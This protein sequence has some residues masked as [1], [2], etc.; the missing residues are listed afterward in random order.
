M[1]SG[2][3]EAKLMQRIREQLLI[4]H[5]IDHH[6]RSTIVVSPSEIA[7]AAASTPRLNG[8]PRRAPHGMHDRE[9][10]VVHGRVHH[11][12]PNVV[13]DPA[14]VRASHLLIRVTDQRSEERALALATQLYD[15]LLKGAD[16]EA[17]A[18]NYSEGP[19]AADGGLLGWVRPGE[20]LPELDHALFRLV[21][22][23]LSSPIRTRLGF[24]LVK[25]VERR[26]RSADEAVET[27]QHLEER[28][29]QEKFRDA[30]HQWLE[31]LRQRAYIEF[32]NE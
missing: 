18:R 6:V 30:L 3:T 9:P 21:P 24:H 2:L 10:D 8:A 4:Q 13:Q 12:E 31:G 23:E 15:Q 14:E 22:G 1:E 20:M 5:A 32:I 16:F 28:L 11:P 27:R 7:N 29:Y 19:H 25:V 26:M 17:L